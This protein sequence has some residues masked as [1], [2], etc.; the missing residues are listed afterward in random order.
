MKLA[1]KKTERRFYQTVGE[2]LR[3]RILDGEYRE[4]E[5]LPPERELSKAYDVSRAVIRD[6]IIML[7]LQG[8]VDV[9]QGS[10]VY[11]KTSAIPADQPEQ[12][13]ENL[14]E[15]PN[16]NA[17]PFELLEARQ[18]IESN[19]ARLAATQAREEDLTAIANSLD[20]YIQSIGS[21]VG[22][23]ADKQFHLAIAAAS[24]N[25]EL[26]SLVRTLWA[27]RENNPLWQQLQTRITEKDYQLQWVE[28]HRRV[29]QAVQSRSGDGAFSAMWNHLEN[30]KVFLAENTRTYLK[31]GREAYMLVD[32]A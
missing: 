14:S 27:R 23:D 3:Q 30:V 25:G 5:R 22:E 24:Q 7:E 12:D 8:I 16:Y 26:V 31:D 9:R 18:L 20:A 2:Q 6:A 32:R 4:G 1:D 13:T 19:I 28:D 29:F 17:G 21:S 10:G 11:V 15:L